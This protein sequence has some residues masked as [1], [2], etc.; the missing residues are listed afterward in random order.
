MV[1]AIKEFWLWNKENIQL[2]AVAGIVFALFY[3][4]TAIAIR[5]FF[6]EK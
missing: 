3:E 1:E 4:G 6:R 2:T 5:R